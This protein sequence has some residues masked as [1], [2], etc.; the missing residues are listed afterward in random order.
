MTERPP[1][2]GGGAD[3]R[4]FDVAEAT[5]EIEGVALPP[6]GKYELDINHTVVGFEARH[7]MTKVRGRFTEFEGTIDLAERPEDS[8]VQVEAKTA[9]VESSVMKRDD[10]LRSADFFE[11]EKWPVL[12]FRSTAVRHTGGTSFELDGDLTVRDVTKPITFKGEYL[13][14]GVD[15]FGNTIFSAEARATVQREDWGLTWN[16][17]IETGG[18]LVSKSIDLVIDVEAHKVG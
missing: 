11:S 18:W 6:A 16:M 1:Q 8:S 10:H 2:G 13:G 9:S 12:T 4:R 15:P 17:A 14:T 5:R 3:P 7:I